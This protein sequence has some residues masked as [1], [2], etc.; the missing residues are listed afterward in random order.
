MMVNPSHHQLLQHNNIKDFKLK[1][2]D[3]RVFN[4]KVFHIEF[5]SLQKYLFKMI[6]K[7]HSGKKIF[8]RIGIFLLLYSVGKK[9][10]K[11]KQENEFFN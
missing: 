6:Q 11:N 10:L 8:V 7:N 1:S 3:N 5:F 9:I 4:H 2:F